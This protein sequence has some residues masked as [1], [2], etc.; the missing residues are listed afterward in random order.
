MPNKVDE[1]FYKNLGLFK[2]KGADKDATK[3]KLFNKFTV[4]SRP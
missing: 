3:I 2:L 4:V 1:I